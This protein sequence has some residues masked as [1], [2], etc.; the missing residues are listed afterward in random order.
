MTWT[1]PLDLGGAAG[2]NS[3]FAALAGA[4]NDDFRLFYM[5]DAGGGDTWN[6]YFRR[7]TNAGASWTAPVDISDATS[8]PP[9]VSPA[10][11]QEPYGDYGEIAVMPNGG[12]F[13]TWGEGPSYTGPGGTWINRTS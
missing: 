6:T 12:T 8:G 4:G 10:G 3:N 9:Y 5:Q 1:A 11:F 7:S 2:T 13:A